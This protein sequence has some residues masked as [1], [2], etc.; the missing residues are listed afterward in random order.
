MSDQ[1]DSSQEYNSMS[2]KSGKDGK[3]T[4]TG[5]G[6]IA[7]DAVEEDLNEIDSVDSNLDS[8]NSVLDF[9]EQRTDNIRAQLLELLTSSREIRQSIIEEN[10]QSLKDEANKNQNNDGMDMS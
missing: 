8:I 5:P 3:T 1:N 7:T 10:G 2:P 9:I 4:S 6:P